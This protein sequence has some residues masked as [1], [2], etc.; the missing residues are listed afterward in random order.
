MYT[1]PVTGLAKFTEYEF[2]VL[3]F[4]S[5]GDGMHSSVQ[6]A[7]TK[8]DTPSKPPSG[9]TVT[10]RNSTSVTASWQLPPAD[11]RNGIIKGFKLFINSKGSDDERNVQFIDVSNDV[12]KRI[13]TGLQESTEYELQVLA[14]T[15]AGD[16]TNSSVQ[17]VKTLKD[18]TFSRPL[19]VSGPGFSMASILGFS[20]GGVSLL[21]FLFSCYQKRK[22]KRSAKWTAK[23][24]KPLKSCEIPPERIESLEE[25]YQGAFGKVHK[26]KLIDGLEFFNKNTK[27]WCE[28]NFKYKIVAVKELH[29]NATEEQKYEFLDV[30]ETMKVVGKNLNVLNFVGCW[31]T[32]TP[33][34]LIVEYIPHGDLLQWLRAKRS[35]IKISTVGAT[36]VDEDEEMYNGAREQ[37]LTTDQ[38]GQTEE[39]KTILYENI[40]PSISVEE[41][42][43]EVDASVTIE[44]ETP[45]VTFSSSASNQEDASTNNTA[46][47]CD[48]DCDSFAPLDPVKLAWQVAR[49]MTYLSQKGL[50]H[51][52]LAARNILV[53]HGKKVKI[54]D[55][56]LMRHLYH[57]V[58]KVDTGKKL[59]VKW[60][61]PESLFEEIFT[62]KT[63]VWSYGVV[64]WEIATLGGSPYALM[65]NK[66]LLQNLKAGYRLEKPDMCTDPVYA[67]MRDCWNQDPDERPSF[68]R[69]YKRLDDM[70]EEQE[71]Y[72]DFGKKD[73]S[74]YYYTTQEE[75][76]A[77]DDELDNLDV[78]SPQGVSTGSNAA[79]AE[80]P[81]IVD[82]ENPQNVSKEPDT[83]DV[84]EQENI[85]DV[86]TQNVPMA[87]L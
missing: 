15:S 6:F 31:T 49:G 74:K 79:E 37:N 76:T 12:Y 72:F 63:D 34:R 36:V 2:H 87:S 39:E 77:E 54:G 26:A 45:F 17:F 69:L 82:V 25:V 62:T 78:V 9:F 13:V 22:K 68:Q 14:Y 75:K 3:A 38:D 70:L 33:L 19:D 29:E 40:G 57:E 10:A 8:E 23:D 46:D 32:A 24:I 5:A 66:Q 86:G 48:E 11:S 65:K 73:D 83:S 52:D 42:G 53:G 16:G 21:G 55:F 71:D 58:Y 4:T 61:A 27:D 64:L 43:T 59:P 41:N 56:G 30:I 50:V 85:Q 18:A 1:I 47:E 44:L 60:M 20:I 80:E 28:K 81:A 51:R 84:Y 35:K 7:K 67:L